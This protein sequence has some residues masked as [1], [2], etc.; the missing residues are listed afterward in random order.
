MRVTWRSGWQAEG[1]NEGTAQVRTQR[2]IAL[3]GS[4]DDNV[5]GQKNTRQDIARFVQNSVVVW[6]LIC[7]S[8]IH[9]RNPTSQQ[10]LFNQQISKPAFCDASFRLYMATR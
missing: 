6:D 1:T 8:R 4:L 7:K 10:R 9:V 2:A 3:E 5:V